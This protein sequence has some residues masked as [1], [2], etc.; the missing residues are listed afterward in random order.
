MNQNVPEVLQGLEEDTYFVQGVAPAASEQPRQDFRLD[1]RQMPDCRFAI[2][3]A[4][5]LLYNYWSE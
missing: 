2:R 5:I 3:D 4:T 1:T